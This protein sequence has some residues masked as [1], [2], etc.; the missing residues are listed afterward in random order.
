MN[1]LFD[2]TSFL[3]IRFDYNF[4]DLLVFFRLCCVFWQKTVTKLHT[5]NWFKP[6]VKSIKFLFW[7]FQV[8]FQILYIKN[9]RF[10]SQ[11]DWNGRREKERLPRVPSHLTMSSLLWMFIVKAILNGCKSKWGLALWSDLYNL[12]TVTPPDTSNL[13]TYFPNFSAV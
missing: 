5:K 7:L 13:S 2:F 1:L 6:C 4:A 3:Y 9:W 8:I 10:W 11:V 12:F